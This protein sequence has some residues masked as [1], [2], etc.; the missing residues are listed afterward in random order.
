MLKVCAWCGKRLP[1]GQEADPANSEYP[2][3][4]GI[5]ESCG[6]NL[7]FQTGVDLARYLDSLEQPVVLLDGDVKVLRAN[8]AALALLGKEPD[9][10]EGFRGGDVFECPYARHPAGCGKTEHCSGCSIRRAV[11]ETMESGRGKS[12]MEAFLKQ[13]SEKGVSEKRLRISTEKVGK[14]VFLRIDGIC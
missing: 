12:V 14:L 6:D 2:V 8:A 13:D 11:A 5:C 3:T 4:H 9:A 1:G 7:L 10:V